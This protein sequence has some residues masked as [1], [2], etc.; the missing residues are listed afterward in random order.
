MKFIAEVSTEEI[1]ARLYGTGKKT[2]VYLVADPELGIFSDLESCPDL[3]CSVIVFAVND[4]FRDLTPWPAPGVMPGDAPFGGRASEFAEKILEIGKKAEQDY[5]IA[6]EHRYIAG[7]S[8]GGLFSIWAVSTYPG[9]NGFGSLSGSVWYDGLFDYM[10]QSELLSQAGKGYFCIGDVENDTPIER[11]R[12][13]LPK[14]V[15]AKRICDA[16]GLDTTFV[17]EKGDHSDNV[18]ERTIRAIRWLT[19]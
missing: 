5:A 7:H 10:E 17:L 11:F 6:A 9:F 1:R 16:L 13:C 8:L 18:T 4:W 15:K 2:V 3:G 19:E 14:T 12:D